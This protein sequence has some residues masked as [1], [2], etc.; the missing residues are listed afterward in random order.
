MSTVGVRLT[1]PSNDF[2]LGNILHDGP[3]ARIQLTPLVPTGDTFVPY[4]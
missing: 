1:F 4:F 3:D 2:E